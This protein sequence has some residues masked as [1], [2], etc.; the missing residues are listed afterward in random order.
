MFLIILKLKKKCEHG[1]KKLTYLLIYVPDQ[2]NT[3]QMCDKAILENGGK[4]VIK[5]F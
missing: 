2:Y 1:V 4:C 5:Q 3:Q